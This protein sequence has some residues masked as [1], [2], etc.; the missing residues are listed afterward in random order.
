MRPA[1]A[2]RHATQ[3]ARSSHPLAPNGQSGEVELIR[4]QLFATERCGSRLSVE[5]WLVHRQI[6]PQAENELF[7]NWVGGALLREK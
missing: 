5:H 6:L 3:L 1:A 4:G 7:N 2:Q